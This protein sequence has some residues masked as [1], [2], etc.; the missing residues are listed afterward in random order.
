MDA[1]EDELYDDLGFDEAEG[2]A[3]TEDELGMDEFGDNFEDEYEEGA[4]AEAYD[5]DPTEFDD[6]SEGFDEYEAAA[7]PTPTDAFDEE[8]IDNVMAYALGAEDA[9]EFFGRLAKGFK[10]AVKRVAPAV[11]R[12]AGGV[13]KVARFIP[14]PYAKAIGGAASLISRGANLAQQLRMEGASEE[15]AL[16]VFAELAAS[17][18]RALP[19]LAGVTARTVLKTQ[20]ARMSAGARKQAIRHMKGAAKTLVQKRGP[21]AARALPKIAKSVKRNA[22]AK[23]ASPASTVK[24][25][26]RAA[27][28]VAGSPALT[29]KLARPSPLARRRVVNGVRGSAGQALSYTIQG[30]ARITITA[31]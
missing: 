28:K 24:V 22:A 4:E 1:L 30:P 20:G 14:H 23:G 3:A 7:A 15:D 8:A 12:I 10:N 31:G 25:V 13:A 19:M 11:S 17:D 5:E 2:P 21:A 16:D 9:D 29:R 6:F 26:R 18:P 27:A